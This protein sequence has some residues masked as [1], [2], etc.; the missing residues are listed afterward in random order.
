MILEGSVS[1][2]AA[3]LGGRRKVC[4]VIADRQKN[5][6]DLR[7]ILRQAEASGIPAE[8]VSPEEIAE[9]AAGRT[10]GGILAEAEERRYDSLAAC[11]RG[12][13]PFLFLIEGV[14]DPFNLG[15]IVRTLYSCGC[16]GLILRQRNWQ[17]AEPLILKASAGAFDRMN[18]VMSE[19]P[20]AEIRRLKE[21]G[22][23][24]FA[25]M[26]KDAAVYDEIDYTVPCVIAVGGEMR[27]LSAGVRQETEKNI[28]IPYANDFRN[29][30]NASGAAAVLGFEVFRQRRKAASG[31]KGER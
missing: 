13:N 30:L 24:C 6:R 19:D 17:T 16:G 28:Y 27:G 7:F 21:R 31:G 26:R 14:E 12:E 8:R 10:H 2:K 3:V 23:R 15:Y 1:V 29:A 9:L 18:I 25:A 20:A 11:C 4:R 22:Y 5:D